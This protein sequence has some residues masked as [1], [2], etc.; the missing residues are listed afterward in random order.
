[1]KLDK[2]V[3]F[4][5]ATKTWPVKVSADGKLK[6]NIL[7]PVTLI[8]NVLYI[9]AIIGVIYFSAM[10]E[11]SFEKLS[12]VIDSLVMPMFS[13]FGVFPI[14]QALLTVSVSRLDTSIFNSTANV[15]VCTLVPMFIVLFLFSTSMISF[16]IRLVKFKT[17]LT[18]AEQILAW[19]CLIFVDSFHILIEFGILFF[20][21]LC[22]ALLKEKLVEVSRLNT[23]NSDDLKSLTH[24][25]NNVNAALDSISPPMFF[26]LQV[27]IISAMYLVIVNM[28]DTFPFSS[29]IFCLC[30][31]IFVNDFLNKLDGCYILAESISC[32]A[33]EELA[34]CKSMSE[35]LVMQAAIS[36][37]ESCFPFTAMRYF[38]LERSTLISMA[39]NTLTY[40]IVLVQFGLD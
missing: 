24:C 7:N 6:S 20:F 3:R 16:Q 22:C 29:V 19:I 31:L 23:I 18:D 39:A 30:L 17:D 34:G 15:K 38:S 4:L 27:A 5:V 21:S 26:M 28:K 37:M 12:H 13:G 25:A 33:K 11:I 35:V 36:E 9:V 10:T 32:K 40:I 2:I 14:F 1:M 8:I